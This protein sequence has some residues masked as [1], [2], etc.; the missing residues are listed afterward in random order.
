MGKGR[1][2]EVSVDGKRKYMKLE[3]SSEWA[4][5]I[6]AGDFE[7][8]R[9]VTIDGDASREAS[10]DGDNHADDIEA[11]RRASIDGDNH[12]APDIATS[13]DSTDDGH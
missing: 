9:E 2:A 3:S 7:A 8:S 1:T 11:S 10:I 6:D 12:A 5:S 4:A 13:D